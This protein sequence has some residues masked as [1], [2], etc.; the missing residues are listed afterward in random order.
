MRK[1]GKTGWMEHAACAQPENA[2]IMDDLFGDER[3]QKKYAITV[4]KGCPVVEPCAEYAW[5][6]RFDHGV[7]GGATEEQRRRQMGRTS[8]RRIA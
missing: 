2:D 4:C 3:Q 1:L 7:F 5:L 6:N 8:R